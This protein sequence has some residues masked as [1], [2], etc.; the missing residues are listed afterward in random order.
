MK[1]LIS[2]LVFLLVVTGCAQLPPPP[3]DSAAKQFN[4]VPGKA[5]IY[6]VRTHDSNWPAPVM[7]DGVHIG[8][9]Y[10]NTF[11]RIETSPG[12]HDLR[13]YGGDSAQASIDTDAG[14][15]Y[16]VAQDVHSRRSFYGSSM[17]A[18]SEAQGREWALGGQLNAVI[19]Q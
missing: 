17:W 13:G 14:K 9:T 1:R 2:G 18:I 19:T 3:G 7:F 16:F 10:G 8:S 11:I 15:L 5:V 12:H 6:L 4:A